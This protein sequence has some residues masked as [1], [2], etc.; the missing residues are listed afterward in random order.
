MEDNRIKSKKTMNPK[1]KRTIIALCLALLFAFSFVFGYFIKDIFGN[2]ESAKVRDVIEL[3]Y[4]RGLFYDSDSLEKIDVTASDIAN[5]VIDDYL[6]EYSKYYTKEEYEAVKKSDD[7]EYDGIGLTFI[8]GETTINKVILN[9][10]ADRIGLKKGDI[11]KAFYIN[12][13]LYQITSLD[14]VKEYLKLAEEGSPFTVYYER[15]GIESSGEISKEEYIAS[16]I[17]YQDNSVT[18]KFRTV[19]GK[20]VFTEIKDGESSVGNPLLDEKTAII[21]Y[22]GFARGSFEEM[23]TAFNYLKAHGKTKLILDLRDNGGGF[24]NILCDVSSFFIG[25]EKIVAYAEDSAGIKTHFVSSKDCYQ[26]YLE[27]LSVIANEN[28]ASASECLLNALL[29]YGKDA[30]YNFTAEKL[31]VENRDDSSLPAHTYGKGVMQETYELSRGGALK[32]TAAFI[33]SPD[34]KTCVQKKNPSGNRGIEAVLGNSAFNPDDAL[35]FAI[36]RLN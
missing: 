29:Y 16:Y 33:Y 30:S 3:I 28:T 23:Q 20:K 5:S 13:T 24:M 26:S 27:S 21:T 36:A 14:Q 19:D 22:Q 34:G 32:L 9:S 1:T 4:K 10:P 31:I 18:M 7:G 25:R 8:T 2:G 11:L 15:E 6:D 35:N 17:S 12:G